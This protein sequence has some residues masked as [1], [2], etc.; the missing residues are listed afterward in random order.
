[1]VAEDGE[2]AFTPAEPLD[3]SADLHPGI[4]AVAELLGERFL[5]G[6]DHAERRAQA[7]LFAEGPGRGRHIAVRRALNCCSGIAITA[8]CSI[9]VKLVRLRAKLGGDGRHLVPDRWQL[10]ATGYLVA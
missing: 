3:S 6:R 2:A 1:P 10:G 5:V 8:W 9:E 7:R 4:V